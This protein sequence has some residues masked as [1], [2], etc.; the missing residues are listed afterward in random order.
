MQQQMAVIQSLVHVLN[1]KRNNAVDAACPVI[2]AKVVYQVEL[3][4]QEHPANPVVLAVQVVHRLSVRKSKFHRVVH[5]HQVHP[6][7]QA[8]MVMLAIQADQ[9]KLA[10]QETQDHL[11]IQAH[12]AH[13][14]HL[15]HQ[16][17]MEHAVTAVDQRYQHPMFQV[18]LVNQVNQALMDNQASPVHQDVMDS[19]AMRVHQDH[20]DLQERQERMAMQALKDQRDHQAQQERRVSVLNTARWMVVSSSK[21]AL[22]VN[23]IFNNPVNSTAHRL[24]MRPAILNSETN[25]VRTRSPIICKLHLN[26]Y[27]TQTHPKRETTIKQH[28]QR[29]NREPKFILLLLLLIHVQGNAICGH[30]WHICI[31]NANI[32][33]RHRSYKTFYVNLSVESRVSNPKPKTRSL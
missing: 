16:V 25:L 23:N 19:Q 26:T 14:V 17:A 15:V 8:P 20:L 21:T 7:H 18:N 6:G 10:V 13:Q 22:V 31:S 32:R 28:Q 11:V 3:V 27:K 5:A 9:A 24:H 4:N 29:L 33:R 12:K 1:V 2:Q 30:F